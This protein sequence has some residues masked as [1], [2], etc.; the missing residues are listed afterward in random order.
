LTTSDLIPTRWSARTLHH[1]GTFLSVVAV[2][3]LILVVIW[4]YTQNTAKDV[5]EKQRMDRLAVIENDA[6]RLGAVLDAQRQQFATCANKPIRAPG[7]LTPVAPPAK[8]VARGAAGQSAYPFT[9][10]FT[11]G[12]RTFTCAMTAAG[13]AV[14]CT[15]P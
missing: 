10:V 13:A 6:K 11:T 3:G 4:L 15:T 12:D 9:F 8:N 1:A 14:T 7:C 5:A 2:F